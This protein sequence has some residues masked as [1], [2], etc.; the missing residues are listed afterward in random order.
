MQFKLA[1]YLNDSKKNK[2]DMFDDYKFFEK[3]LKKIFRHIERKTNSE[4]NHTAHNSNII[5]I[6]LCR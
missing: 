6:E 5:D 3:E 2:N 1:E 4:T